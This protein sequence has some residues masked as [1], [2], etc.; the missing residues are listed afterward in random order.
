VLAS[1][2]GASHSIAA[3]ATGVPLDM[4][5]RIDKLTPP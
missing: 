2:A 3:R 1:A 4:K 5:F